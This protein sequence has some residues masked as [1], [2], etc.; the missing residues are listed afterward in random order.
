MPEALDSGR[1]KLLGLS[2][3]TPA[4]PETS[5]DIQAP[6]GLSFFDSQPAW[7]EDVTVFLLCK[8][9]HDWADEYCVT[10]LKL[11]R[12]AAGPKTQLVIVEQL[13]ACAC[14]EPATHEI[15]GAELPVPPKP[16]LPNMGRAGSMA[17]ATDAM[18]SSSITEMRV[19]ADDWTCHRCWVSLTGKNA[20]SR[21]CATCLIRRAG[22]LL[23]YITTL[24]LW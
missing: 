9:L 23:P 19:C 1:V 20:R 12:A 17:H 14:D 21:S 2:H 3:F 18:A 24:R 4:F 13:I 22:S 7:E 6:Q 11:L 10:I 15:P 8:V 5:A 16:L